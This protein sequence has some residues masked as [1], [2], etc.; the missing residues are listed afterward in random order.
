MNER[1]LI[2]DAMAEQVVAATENVS[3]LPPRAALLEILV[4]LFL[5]AAL[6]YFV[7]GFP[8]LA[9]MHPHV[10]WLPVLL[11]SLQYGTIS[12]LLTAG[13]AIALSAALGWPEQDVGEN[14]FSYLLRIWSQPVL[15][16]TAALV[17]GQFRTRQIERK[18]NLIRAVAELSSQRKAL[19]DYA[20]N[21]RDRCDML[22]REISSRRDP[23]A[24]A[25]LNA[26]GHLDNDAGDDI[27]ARLADCLNISFGRC[28][29]AIYAVDGHKLRLINRHSGRNSPI[30][31]RDEVTMSEPLAA[32]IVTQQRGLSVMSPGEE[33]ILG[34]DGV[35]AVPILSPDRQTVLGMLKLEA[36]DA[37][38]LD[39]DIVRR[40]AVI[41]DRISALMSVADQ[42]SRSTNMSPDGQPSQPARQRLWRQ[43]KWQPHVRDTAQSVQKT[44]QRG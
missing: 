23:A 10:F 34:D 8:S 33:S 3:V 36:A 28:Q 14:H 44:Q 38:E 39:R 7:P 4:L 24:R 9:D 35:A 11:L 15:W 17:L 42:R 21:L 30:P 16:L 2:K 12:G 27:Q 32:A 18:E 41:A 6:D 31:A 20:N 19:A 5:P 37:V 26:L 43:L 1:P 29:I 22:E 40:L 13:L 25:L